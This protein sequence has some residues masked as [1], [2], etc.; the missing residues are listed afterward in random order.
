MLLAH[1]EVFLTTLQ[2]CPGVVFSFM[3]MKY[4]ITAGL[5][6]DEPQFHHPLHFFFS[7]CLISSL[8]RR[9]SP[10][11][12]SSL[13]FGSLPQGFHPCHLQFLILP[14]IHPPLAANQIFKNQNILKCFIEKTPHTHTPAH[15]SNYPDFHI[16]V[17]WVPQLRT[18]FL[19]GFRGHVWGWCWFWLRF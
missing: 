6:W 2:Q 17:N 8:S 11:L 15:Q 18:I 19:G 12:L 10:R 4:V 1:Q 7:Q 5:K 9:T 3:F 16:L 13:N 14:S